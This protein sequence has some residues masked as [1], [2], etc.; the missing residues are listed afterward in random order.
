MTLSSPNDVLRAFEELREGHFPKAPWPLVFTD[1]DQALHAALKASSLVEKV[2]QDDR[3]DPLAER[4]AQLEQLK[5]VE[6]RRELE[7]RGHSSKGLKKVLLKKLKGLVAIEE[8][9]INNLPPPKAASAQE[10]VEEASQKTSRQDPAPG[11]PQQH[12][13]PPEVKNEAVKK[14]AVVKEEPANGFGQA[15]GSDPGPSS[16]SEAPIKLEF[17]YAILDEVIGKRLGTLS[18]LKEEYRVQIDVDIQFDPCFVLISGK[19]EGMESARMVLEERI[20]TCLSGAIHTESIQ[21]PYSILQQVSGWDH[22]ELD[23]LEREAC[24]SLGIDNQ[25]DPCLIHVRGTANGV[26]Q[27]RTT[28]QTTIQEIEGRTSADA[29]I[30]EVMDCPKWAAGIVI[31]RGGRTLQG[32]ERDT[33]TKINVHDKDS[34]PSVRI[35]IEGSGGNVAR[36]REV[37]QHLISTVEEDYESTTTLDFPRSAVGYLFGK[38]G[39]TIKKLQSDTR[40]KMIVD[41]D[42]DPCRVTIRGSQACVMHATELV[43]EVLKQY[44]EE[45]A[46]KDVIESREGQV[47]PSNDGRHHFGA[48]V[49]QTTAFPHNGVSET[50]LCPKNAVAL[51]IGKG[52]STVRGI[53]RDTQTKIDIRQDRDPCRVCITGT[54]E[55]VQLAVE[56]VNTMMSNPSNPPRPGPAPEADASVEYPEET[57]SCP[58]HLVPLVIGKGGSTVRGIERDTQTKID[59]RQES[60]HMNR[61]CIT[62]T[63][64]GVQL[65]VEMVKQQ[66]STDRNAQQSSGFPHELANQ[67]H[68]GQDTSEERFE[69]P[70]SLVGVVIGS[71]GANVKEIQRKSGAR[72]DILQD[73]DPCEIVICGSK[74]SVSKA[75]QAVHK[76][77]GGFK[78]KT[79]NTVERVEC[80]KAA[81]GV[82]IGSHGST[83]KEIQR[84][85]GA[86]IEILHQDRDPCEVV[87]KGKKECVSRA[88]D[89]VRKVILAA[90]VSGEMSMTMDCPRVYVGLI[91]GPK[92]VNVK[93]IERATGVR[94]DINQ[95]PDPCRVTVRGPKGKVQ[96]AVERLRKLISDREGL[97]AEGSA[98][99]GS[100]ETSKMGDL[101]TSLGKKRSPSGTPAPSSAK[102]ARAASALDRLGTT[103]VGGPSSANVDSQR[104]VSELL[105]KKEKRA[106]R[107]GTAEAG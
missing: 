58:K 107:F 97:Q 101:R 65:A 57:I 76:L 51:V 46:V 54:K 22:A 11:L 3:G 48:G 55:G 19:K 75:S 40:T 71:R 21:C 79:S 47:I 98:G 61:V 93:R 84:E 104:K 10:P 41:K 31:G 72:V 29:W 16:S 99:L 36:A 74:E 38:Q 91:I 92:G 85:S 27:A 39:S 102:K 70:R 56:M 24:V 49:L 95:G 15:R 43:K 53:E 35:E 73:R 1:Y 17:P 90:L 60:D 59:I 63:K 96:D 68:S 32:I 86:T 45:R 94:V 100:P 34:G 5:V 25:Y 20:K 14:E 30:N 105:G 7:K 37:L 4:F 77:V 8:A 33:G 67:I 12:A 69:C 18:K 103:E 9:A 28:L 88:S 64:E 42:F 6:L 106:K 83:M 50:V 2:E 81:V 89:R 23:N 78:E 26:A 66:M 80:P 52:G 87:V 82:V 44:G 62:G 13:N